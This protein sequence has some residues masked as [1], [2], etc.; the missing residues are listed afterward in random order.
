V[1]ESNIGLAGEDDLSQ[2]VRFTIDAGTGRR[3]V[4]LRVTRR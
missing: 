2:Q 1:D 4:R 3:Y